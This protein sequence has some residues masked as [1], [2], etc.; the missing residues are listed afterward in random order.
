MSPTVTGALSGVLSISSNDPASPTA[1]S[2]TA[3]GT[4][5][6]ASVDASVSFATSRNVPQ[7]LPVTLKNTGNAELDVAQVSL[8][9]GCDI[10]ERRRQLWRSTRSRR[11]VQCPDQVLADDVRHVERDPDFHRRR[12]LGAGQQPASIAAG[13][14]V[15]AWNPGNADVRVVSQ[16]RAGPHQQRQPRDHQEHR[17]GRPHH[18]RTPPGRQ[19]A[20][21]LCAG[22][23]DVHRLG[24]RPRQYLQSQRAI[25]SDQAG[26]QVGHARG[27]RTMPGPT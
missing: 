16:R 22:K 14:S 3:T 8:D 27:H 2:L 17:G 9:R 6:Q 19:R 18:L 5:P 4:V 25:R 26:R 11:V 23:A 1:V 15:A 13:H 24:N 20:E 7:T 21:E 10:L 12:R